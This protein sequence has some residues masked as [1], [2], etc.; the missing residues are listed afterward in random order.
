MPSRRR[1]IGLRIGQTGSTS[2]EPDNR[3]CVTILPYGARKQSLFLER[4]THAARQIAPNSDEGA[5]VRA[6]M[7]AGAV[8]WAS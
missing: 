2:Q 4:R 8:S 6:A 7:C 1:W 3:Y 5:R